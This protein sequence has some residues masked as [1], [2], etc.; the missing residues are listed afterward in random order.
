MHVRALG[1]GELARIALRAADAAHGVPSGLQITVDTVFS[2]T[3]LGLAALLLW[4]RP[5]HWGARLLATAFVGAAG[6]FNLTA[7]AAFEQLPLTAAGSVAQAGAHTIAGLAYVYA[8][9]LFPDGRP[10]PRWRPSAIAGLYL[11][12]T[13]A[14][15]YLSI[16]VEGTARPAAL[17]LF[18]GV[19]VPVV[20]TAA[21]GYR[22]HRPGDETRHAQARLLFWALLPSVVF[23][24]LFLAT[25][26]VTGTSTT[27]AGRHL[28]EAPVTLYRYFQPAFALIPMA[29]F[30]GLLRY[31]LWDIERLLNRTIVYAAAT[32]LLGGVYLLFV[33]VLQQALGQVAATPIIENRLVVA[34]TTLLLASVFRPVRDRVQRFVDRRFHRS[35][36]DAQVTVERFSR[37]LRDQVEPDRIAADLSAVLAEVVGPRSADLWL[38]GSRSRGDE[39]S[40]QAQ[41]GRSYS[42]GHGKG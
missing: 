7:Q 27:F 5:R 24:V 21:Q 4:L 34:I 11:G 39:P 30:A 18:F 40:A 36:Y 20:G 9:L 10:V 8:L 12:V 29:L 41:P 3:H 22:L 6:V 33:V 19:M 26:G 16:R 23:G 2:V 14:A 28:P 37:Q 1:G 17:L 35:R 13:I 31:R 15:V 42:I 32:G 25:H 38:V